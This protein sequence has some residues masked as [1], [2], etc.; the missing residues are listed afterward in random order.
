MGATWVERGDA[1]SAE[2]SPLTY[3]PLGDRAERA[4]GAIRLDACIT[5]VACASVRGDSCGPVA[6]PRSGQLGVQPF[7]RGHL[8]RSSVL[9]AGVCMVVLDIDV[10]RVTCVDCWS[11]VVRSGCGSYRKAGSSL[12]T[13]CWEFVVQL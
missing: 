3:N 4:V 11:L 7:A 6:Q 10:V 2:G 12:R 13:A 9:R 8:R 5:I 1:P